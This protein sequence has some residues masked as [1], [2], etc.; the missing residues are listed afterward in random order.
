MRRAFD[1]E[2]WHLQDMSPKSGWASLR[3]SG[4]P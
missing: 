1:P 2:A 4:A 3:G